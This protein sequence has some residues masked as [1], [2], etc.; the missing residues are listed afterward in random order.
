M[1]NK[2]Q[3]EQS[4]HFPL[5][6]LGDPTENILGLLDTSSLEAMWK[7]SHAWRQALIKHSHPIN[8]R[9]MQRAE[10]I[11]I[12]IDNCTNV[13]TMMTKP[14]HTFDL[15]RAVKKIR[16]DRKVCQ[17]LLGIDVAEDEELLHLMF[18]Q[19]ESEKQD[20]L[21]LFLK[22][23][24]VAIPDIMLT[25]GTLLIKLLEHEKNQHKGVGSL[26][27][28]IEALSTLERRMPPAMEYLFGLVCY[29]VKARPGGFKDERTQ[30][31]AVGLV[32]ELLEPLMTNA[33]D[34]NSQTH[35]LLDVF[36]AFTAHSDEMAKC[37][38][39]EV[40]TFTL[41]KVFP[42]TYERHINPKLR[43]VL[44]TISYLAV[45]EAKPG[46][47]RKIRMKIASLIA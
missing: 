44:T 1:A 22:F 13:G 12:A 17:L 40:A 43:L 30:L 38:N 23:E 9:M 34:P 2:T 6:M 4:C 33:F 14:Q 15:F 26:R 20:E 42:V 8:M 37:L 45:N 5:E 10:T 3:T 16:E 18:C 19:E 31:A 25:Y 21:Y 24:T 41:R 32:C 47:L 11:V 27:D 29:V 36:S 7:V 35:L 28:I 46:F 39:K